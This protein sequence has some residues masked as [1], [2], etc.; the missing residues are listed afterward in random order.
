MK[1]LMKRHTC[2]WLLLIAL[3]FAACNS[4]NEG[5]TGQQKTTLQMLSCQKGFTPVEETVTRSLPTGFTETSPSNGEYIMLFLATKTENYTTYKSGTF[6]YNQTEKKWHTT[7]KV[8]IEATTNCRIYGYMP[9][10]NSGSIAP[11]SGSIA[12]LNGSYENGAVMTFSSLPPITTSDPCVITGIKQVDFDSPNATFVPKDADDVKE[13]CF[14]YTI[15]AS[16][17][18]NF[19]YVLLDHLYASLDF[20]FKVNEEYAKLRTI[21]LKKVELKCT[22]AATVS[23]TVTLRAN[24]EGASPIEN[25]EWTHSG[26]GTDY[27]EIFTSTTDTGEELNTDYPVT[28]VASAQFAPI[29][30][31]GQSMTL[32]CTY[33]VYTADGSKTP[34]SINRVAENRITQ[35]VGMT[36]GQ[37][38]TITVTVN[39]TYLYVLADPDL[40]NPTISID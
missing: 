13:G 9:T 4:D 11:L 30:S 20:K 26:S 36:R 40:D 17:Q 1:Q 2:I 35:V 38:R 34:I 12:P 3:V 24:N 14:D 37:K 5:E 8:E 39:P 15:R 33:N 19:L 23:A 31:E 18:G 25:T 32:R 27:V 7:N 16:L 10:T 28:S 22:Q 21:K 29:Y 6:T